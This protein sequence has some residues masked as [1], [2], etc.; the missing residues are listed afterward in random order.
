M[1]DLDEQEYWECIVCGAECDPDKGY[2]SML[3]EMQD[4]ED[5]EGEWGD[6]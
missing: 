2:C 3:C 1:E 6:S 5:A 4:I